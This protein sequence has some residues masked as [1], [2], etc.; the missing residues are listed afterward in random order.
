MTRANGGLRD[1]VLNTFVV[2]TKRREYDIAQDAGADYA[3][4][5][6][7][8]QW[9]N[10]ATRPRTPHGKLDFQ[11]FNGYAP[12]TQNSPNMHCYI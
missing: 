7:W 12:I 1:K 5:S 6:C 2:K 9:C 8:P 4:I 11:A 3:I 10:I